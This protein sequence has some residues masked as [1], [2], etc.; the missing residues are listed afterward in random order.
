MRNILLGVGAAIVVIIGVSIY[1]G[2]FNLAADA[3]S[4]SATSR[5]I[6]FARDR[7][8]AMRASGL[9]VPNLA[10]RD[11]IAIGARH[12]AEMCTDCHLAPGVADTEL[13]QGLHPVPPD[14][15]NGTTRRPAESF[16]VIKHGIKMTAMPAWGVTHDDE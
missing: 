4:W 15:T 2:A 14:F 8:I 16:W 7:S 3:P 13:R 12:Y 5:A 11:L 10:D 6:E 9:T 1:F